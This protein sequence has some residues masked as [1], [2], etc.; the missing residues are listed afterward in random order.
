[1]SKDTVLRQT[2]NVCGCTIYMLE[3]GV[4]PINMYA[5]VSVF[6][7]PP[8]GWLEC[9]RGY[10]DICPDCVKELDATLRNFENQRRRTT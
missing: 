8:E 5:E 7:D 4:K 1:M 3:I 2:C 10:D 6:E 9:Y